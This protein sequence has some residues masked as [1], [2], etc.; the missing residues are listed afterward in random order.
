LLSSV[1][2]S[3]YQFFGTLAHLTGYFASN[4]AQVVSKFSFKESQPLQCNITLLAPVFIS[5]YRFSGTLA[6][7]AGYFAP[8][9]AQLISMFSFKDS[10]LEMKCNIT[11][12][13]F[14][15]T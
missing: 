3:I 2:I 15:G 7:L 14:F 5:I 4:K 1:F 8:N 13:Q 6:H 10:T 9:K 12:Y 11:I